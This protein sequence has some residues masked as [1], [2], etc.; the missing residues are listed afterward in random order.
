MPKTRP[1]SETAPERGERPDPRGSDRPGPWGDLPVS[2]PT[3]PPSP[4]APTAQLSSG[5]RVPTAPPSDGQGTADEFIHIRE[6]ERPEDYDRRW[7]DEVFRGRVPQLTTRAVLTGLALGSILAISNLYVGLKAGWTLG[8]AITACVASSALWR[9]LHRAGLSRTP[10]GIL[11]QNCM[12]STASAAGFTTASLL[13]T[14]VPAYMLMTGTRIGPG[15]RLTARAKGC[16]LW[17]CFLRFVADKR[18]TYTR[19]FSTF[20]G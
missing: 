3:K 20:V 18:S 11:E 7:R 17:A 13:V 8:V 15:W 14:A 16:G 19:P 12:Q 9:G 2:S 6:G 1:H 5:G 10:M 4:E